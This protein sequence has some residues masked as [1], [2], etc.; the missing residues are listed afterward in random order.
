[1]G[2][3][4]TLIEKKQTRYIQMRLNFNALILLTVIA[5][6]RAK[7]VTSCTEGWE[8]HGNHCFKWKTHYETWDSAQIC[9]E[10]ENANLASIT[11]DAINQYVLEGMRS[12]NLSHI[13]IGG[14]D[15]DEEGTWKWADGSLFEFTFWGSEEPNSFGGNEDCMVHG[16]KSSRYEN[17]WNDLPCTT[18]VKGL[19]CGKKICSTGARIDQEQIDRLTELA[20]G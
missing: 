15:K 10:S 7:C 20:Q 2:I 4:A 11:S 1:M 14:N 16:W 18:R 9:C 5:K 13:W 3:S 19:L 6:G 12:R 8:T 17:M